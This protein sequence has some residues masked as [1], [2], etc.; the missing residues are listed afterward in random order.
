MKPL[1]VMLPAV[2]VLGLISLNPPVHAQK[3]VWTV[4]HGVAF[5][6]N[7]DDYAAYPAAIQAAVDTAA[8]GDKIAVGPGNY[9]GAKVTKAIELV[10]SGGE[11]AIVSGPLHPI[12]GAMGARVGFV[13]L[14]AAGTTVRQF[15][16]F[17]SATSMIIAVLVV[18]SD[19]V[20]V[21]HVSIQ[22]PLEAINV[23]GSR[24]TR[25]AHN[26]VT[27]QGPAKFSA[28][29]LLT[30]AKWGWKGDVSDN[31]VAHNTIENGVG[32]GIA[33]VAPSDWPFLMTGNTIERNTINNPAGKGIVLT[34]DPLRL[35]GNAIGF[36]DLR[37]S[38]A[39]VVAAS[40]L[41]AVNTFD[42][43]LGFQPPNQPDRGKGSVK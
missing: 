38:G 3:T 5:D 36:N 37:G 31:L 26:V 19:D 41:L 9:I 13:L 33:L 35:Y 18:T 29:N 4:G 17:C 32:G 1:G 22:T 40:A 11:T 28:I 39:E 20:A 27:G 43:N 10:G 6:F 30:G 14:N 34:G 15:K 23:F 12:M 2:V 7:E 8:P 25:I 42:R 21:E 16:F 24:R